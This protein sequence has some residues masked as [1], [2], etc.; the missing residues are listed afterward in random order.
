MLKLPILS[1]K[2]ISRESPALTR[3]ARQVKEVRTAILVN[4]VYS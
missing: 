4:A 3:K 1:F 2:N